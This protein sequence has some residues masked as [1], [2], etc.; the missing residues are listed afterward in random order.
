MVGRTRTVMRHEWMGTGIRLAYV[1]DATAI[2]AASIQARLAAAGGFFIEWHRDPDS[3]QRAASRPDVVLLGPEIDPERVT[4]SALGLE[5]ASVVLCLQPPQIASGGAEESSSP[6]R[7]VRAGP[8][9]E[10]T[11]RLEFESAQMRAGPPRRSP[12]VTRGELPAG[13]L[14]RRSDERYRLV[15]LA[16][17]DGVWDWDLVAGEIS[18]SKRWL[19]MIGLVAAP[20]PSPDVWFDRVHSDDLRVLHEAISTHLEGLTERLSVRY[21][22]RGEDGSYRWMEAS[23]LAASDQRGVPYR[24]VGTQMDVTESVFAEH[25]LATEATHDSLT[26]LANRSLFMSRLEHVVDQG[27]IA[28]DTHFAVLFVDI[29]RFKWVNDSLGHAVGDELLVEL[30][31]RLAAVSRPGDTVSRLAADEFAVLLTGLT[32]PD[33]ASSVAERMLSSIDRRFL[34]AGREIE[35]RAS[36]GIATSR[37]AYGSSDELLRQAG[38]ALYRAKQD[39]HSGYV[40]Y[41]DEVDS[42][43]SERLETEQALRRAL[44]QGDMVLHYQ[45]I[46]D[47][48]TGRIVSFEALVRWEHPERGLL[49]PNQFLTLAE[50]TGLIVPLGEHVL[51]QGCLQLRAWTDRRNAGHL[52]ISVNVS[53]RQLAEAGLVDVVSGVLAETGVEAHR[54]TIEVTEHSVIHNV[55]AAAATLEAIRAL[56]VRVHT[57]DFGSGHAAL[58][59][60]RLFPVDALKIDRSFIAGLGSERSALPFVRAMVTLAHSLGLGVIAEGVETAEQLDVLQ[61]LGCEEAQGYFFAPP[62]SAEDIVD[63][64]DTRPRIVYDD[65]DEL[66]L[67]GDSEL[68][69]D[70]ERFGP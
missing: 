70:L 54:L 8:A 52:S 34:L 22:L 24:L 69:V 35:V 51:R 16:C 39:V 58:S 46:V 28:R 10:P 21:R 49:G 1:G 17:R 66:A 14:I 67:Q 38:L 45:P 57:D 26:G 31:D 37:T 65:D 13:E 68:F 23:A 53:A 61:S 50:Q 44:Q 33:D 6:Y 42:E 48:G 15:A 59:Y 43:A 25:R 7:S 60:L 41:D 20:S 19:E 9:L 29:D 62:R 64:N 55:Q 63:L 32:G 18:Y 12:S 27:L 2:D 36:I 47:L 5:P 4:L 40:V 3:L 30:A 56:G 11:I